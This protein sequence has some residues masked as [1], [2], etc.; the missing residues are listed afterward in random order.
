M[1]SQ[2]SVYSVAAEIK[3][4]FEQTSATRVDCDAKAINLVGGNVVP[5]AIQGAC[6]YSVYAG[7]SQEFVVQFRFESLPLD[8]DV[9]NLAAKIYGSLAPTVTYKGTLG[10][11]AQPLHTYVMTRI[12]GITYLDFILAHGHPSDSQY[13]VACRKTLIIDI[14]Q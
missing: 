1:S 9:V 2:H 4:F 13:N 7:P 10:E 3:A 12:P 5:V 11:G 8:T 14:A 6:S